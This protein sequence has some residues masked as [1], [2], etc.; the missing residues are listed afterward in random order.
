MFLVLGYYFIAEYMGVKKNI[1][2]SFKSSTETITYSKGLNGES[3]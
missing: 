3:E 2:S 1:N